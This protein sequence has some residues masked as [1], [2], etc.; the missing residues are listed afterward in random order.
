MAHEYAND[1]DEAAGVLG[2]VI[3]SR[4][5]RATVR[6]AL[7]NLQKLKSSEE[8][9]ACRQAAGAAGAVP[10]RAGAVVAV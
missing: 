9:E 7:H 8:N 6:L 5:L 10:A 2:S 4:G 1:V 3:G